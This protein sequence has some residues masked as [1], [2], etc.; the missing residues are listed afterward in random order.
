M[1]SKSIGGAEWSQMEAGRLFKEGNGNES[2]RKDEM[3]RAG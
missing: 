2:E 1:K 3:S